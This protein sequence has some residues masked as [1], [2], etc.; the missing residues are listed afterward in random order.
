M[1]TKNKAFCVTLAVRVVVY[2]MDARNPLDEEKARRTALKQMEDQLR[3]NCFD[4][5]WADTAAVHTYGRNFEEAVAIASVEEMAFG[6]R[7]GENFRGLPR[8]EWHVAED[9]AET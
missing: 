1:S 5:R 4:D 7:K 9:A 3:Y 8:H 2:E 6:L